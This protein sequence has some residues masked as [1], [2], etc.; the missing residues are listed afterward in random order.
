RT[1]R[2]EAGAEF[3]KSKRQ[4]FASSR[5]EPSSSRRCVAS[6]TTTHCTRHGG[7]QPARCRTRVEQHNRTLKMIRRDPRLRGERMRQPGVRA[8]PQQDPNGQGHQRRWQFYCGCLQGGGPMMA[9]ILWGKRF[10]HF[11]AAGLRAL[12]L[13]QAIAEQTAEAATHHG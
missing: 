2:G 10:A 8:D 12:V 6:E 13:L 7:L 4:G 1:N 3:A 5:L 11:G 9:L